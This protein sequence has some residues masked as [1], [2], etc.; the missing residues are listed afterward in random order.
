MDTPPAKRFKSSASRS[1]DATQKIMKDIS[2]IPF[3]W[4]DAV[5]PIIKEWFEAFAKSH[6]TAPE[7]VFMGALVTCAALMGPLTCVH[8]K[9]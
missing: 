1:L 2:S 6:N 3:P 8:C 5:P 4:D 9:K 7:Y